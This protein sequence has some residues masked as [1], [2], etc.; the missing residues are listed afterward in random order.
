MAIRLPGRAQA[1]TWI[2]RKRNT[3]GVIRLFRYSVFSRRSSF[4]VRPSSAFGAQSVDDHPFLRIEAVSSAHRDQAEQRLQCVGVD[5]GDATAPR[6]DDVDVRCDIQIVV[7]VL[8]AG[9]IEL[10][11]EAQLFQRGDRVVDGRLADRRVHG[12]DAIP[13][14]GGGRVAAVRQQRLTDREALRSDAP[15]ARRQPCQELIQFR[16][17]PHDRIILPQIIYNDSK[18]DRPNCQA[19]IKFQTRA[20]YLYAILGGI[21]EDSCDEGDERIGA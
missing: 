17:R 20:V 2:I 15:P 10:L 1:R 6:A 21:K 18:P 11:N 19:E 16:I 4:I 7:C 13:D 9:D 8:V 5:I 12:V 3:S 14:F